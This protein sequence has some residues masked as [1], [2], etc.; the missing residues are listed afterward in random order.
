MLLVK[1]QVSFKAHNSK[2]DNN[3]NIFSQIHAYKP[4]PFNV[5]C[6]INLKKEHFSSSKNFFLKFALGGNVLLAKMATKKAKPNG[7][8]YLKGDDVMD[9]MKDQS[10]QNIPGINLSCFSLFLAIVTVK[11][12]FI[13]FCKETFFFRNLLFICKIMS[14]FKCI[15][16]VFDI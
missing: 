9:F 14:I 10:V 3:L 16:G 12:V 1:F 13:L 4:C 11:L 15:F 5:C 7:Q 8:F 2:M 6:Q